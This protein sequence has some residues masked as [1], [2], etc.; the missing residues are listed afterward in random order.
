[1]RK[2]GIIAII[3]M[4]FGLCIIES[5]KDGRILESR[6]EKL[7]RESAKVI[8]ILDMNTRVDGV[9]AKTEVHEKAIGNVAKILQQ[10]RSVLKQLQQQNQKKKK[11]WFSWLKKK[12]NTSK[13]K[14]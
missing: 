8:A 4:G 5:V 12:Q 14:K 1:M 9:E 3:L 13:G 11:G 2:T 10:H 7:E 6:M